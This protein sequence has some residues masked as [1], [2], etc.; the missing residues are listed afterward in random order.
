MPIRIKATPEM[1]FKTVGDSQFPSLLPI[2]TPIALLR[3]RAPDAAANIIQLLY[4]LSVA[5]SIVASWVL[6]PSSAINTDKKIVANI[7]KSILFYLITIV[8]HIPFS[9]WPFIVQLSLYMPGVTG[10][11]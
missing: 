8:P 1:F 11:K 7:F 6:S 4:F 3:T 10:T 5:K 2:N 9:V